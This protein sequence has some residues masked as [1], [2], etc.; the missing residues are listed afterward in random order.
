MRK[1][2]ISLLFGAGAGLAFVIVAAACGGGPESPL[3]FPTAGP[4]EILLTVDG[5]PV[6]A[7]GLAVFELNGLSREQALD[8]MINGLVRL[9]AAQRLGLEASDDEARE[10]LRDLQADWAKLDDQQWLEAEALLIAQGM[11]TTNI[12]DDPEWLDFGR[13]V[14]T[15][16][17]LGI[18]LEERVVVAAL[19]GVSRDDI[20][21]PG[22]LAVLTAR[23]DPDAVR[24]AKRDR[25]L[26]PI[27]PG[28]GSELEQ[29]TKQERA[30]AE[31]LPISIGSCT[32]TDVTVTCAGGS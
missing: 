12:A 20:N 29:F 7:S 30:K 14:K 32:I 27:T 1:S 24:D 22:E 15:G 4:T 26:R 11:S 18:F 3:V 28:A 25:M 23:L 31:I 13:E 16:I 6:T 8:A 17:K 2:R 21:D 10:Y 9:H 19:T 5:E